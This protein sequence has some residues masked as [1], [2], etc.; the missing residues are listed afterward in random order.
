MRAQLTAEPDCA[1]TA[2]SPIKTAP[3][4][5]TQ[6]SRQPQDLHQGNG[7]DDGSGILTKTPEGQPSGTA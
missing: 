3:V 2:F 5:F 1:M 7:P 4:S 6:S